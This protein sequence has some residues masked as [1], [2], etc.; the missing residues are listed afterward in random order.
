MTSVV[1]GLLAEHELLGGNIPL[2]YWDYAVEHQP[3]V[4]YNQ[5]PDVKKVDTS[6]W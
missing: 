4:T 3:P 1:N 5:T 6:Y 2:G